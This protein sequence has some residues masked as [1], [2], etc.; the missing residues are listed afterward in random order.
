MQENQ[1]LKEQVRT[2]IEANDFRAL[3]TILLQYPPADIADFIS[4]I[5]PEDQGI[6]FRIL[7][8]DLATDTFGY[9]DHDA[10]TKLIDSL[11]SRRVA[12]ILNEMNPDDRTAFL[13]EC[14]AEVTKQL[15]MLL[16]TRERDIA[17]SLLGYPEN[18][19]GRLMT[20]DFLTVKKDWTVEDVFSHVREFGRDTDMVN[21]LY[22]LN[23][24]GKLIDDIRIREILLAAPTLTI[25]NLCRD[26]LHA[27]SAY[28]DK[29]EAVEAFKKYD[30]TALP[31][32]DLQQHIVGIVTVDDVLDVAEEEATEDFQKLAGMEALEEPFTKIPVTRLVRKRAPWLVVLLIGQMLTASAMGFF[33]DQI[34]KAVVLALFVP[35]IISSGGNSG[36]QAATLVIRALS[37]GEVDTGDWL[38]VIFRELLSGLML[39]VI[40]AAV[41]FARIALWAPHGAVGTPPWELLGAIVATSVFC[42]VLWGS[43]IG[44]LFPIVLH[45]LGFDPATSSAPFVATVVDVTGVVIYFTIGTAILGTFT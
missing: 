15:L 8:Q 23:E 31:V 11:G 10:Q 32:V 19:V 9:L 4:D 38:R 42:V 28:Q 3:R 12:K 22:V 43:L 30:R 26:Q 37:L 35:L 29:E 21:V 13:E 36:S 34:A 14:P 41:G 5:E 25:E 2:L 44:A 7:P 33:Q 39:G 24:Q 1:V 17:V 16:S 20:P 27:L 6:I 45:R 40:L 18:S